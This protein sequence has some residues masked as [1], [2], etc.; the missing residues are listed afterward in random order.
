M[1]IVAAAFSWTSAAKAQNPPA[2]PVVS[3]VLIPDQML[4]SVVVKQTGPYKLGAPRGFSADVETPF[5]IA[6]VARRS[7]DPPSAMTPLWASNIDGGFDV[8]T[9]VVIISVYPNAKQSSESA[10][11]HFI[12]GLMHNSDS[13]KP[14]YVY[15]DSFCEMQMFHGGVLIPPVSAHIIGVIPGP[16]TDD[17]EHIVGNSK[18]GVYFYD[19][20]AFD[21]AQPVT[22]KMRCA[23]NPSKWQDV[24]MD[25]KL[26]QRI[27]DQFGA[28]RASLAPEGQ[29]IDSP[30]PASLTH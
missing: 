23:T 12:E 1:L 15:R 17:G 8:H 2:A 13:V 29:I 20:S 22:I 3:S 6:E 21:P 16:D 18:E 14:E 10:W 7:N 5:D 24:T 27:W 9:P 26:Q 4:T 30:S 25:A 19:S 28:Y 11:D